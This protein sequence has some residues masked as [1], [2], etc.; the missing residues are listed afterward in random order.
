MTTSFLAPANLDPILQQIVQAHAS[1]EDEPTSAAI[2]AS[3][4]YLQQLPAEIHWLC[5]SSPLLPVVVQAI[6]LWGYG[7]PPAQAT[8]AAFKPVLAAA[9]ARCPDCAVDWHRQCRRELKRVFTEVYSYDEESTSEFYAALDQWDVERL[10]AAFAN[11]M[12]VVARIPMAWKHV[13]VKGP[14]L[15]CLAEPE[16][17]LNDQVVRQWKGLFLSLEKMPSGFGEKWLPGAV[18]LLFDSDVRVRQFGE[19][20]FKKRADKLQA[21]EFRAHIKSP[22]QKIIQRESQKVQD[23]I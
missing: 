2:I 12:D 8:L 17:L 14:L 4:S 16:L 7:E 5:N 21:D 18:V 9:I 19:H 3:V 1:S 11:A 13:E 10:S 22:L 20:V 6:Q 23:C 15:E